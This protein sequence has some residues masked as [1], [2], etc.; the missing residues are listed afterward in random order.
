MRRPRRPAVPG[1]VIA[2]AFGQ[3]PEDHVRAAELAI[4]RAKR[5]AEPGRHVVV[6]PG[7]LTRLGRARGLA[8]PA[9]T[10]RDGLLTDPAGHAAV[11]SLRRA[12]ATADGQHAI[13]RRW[14]K[15]LSRTNGRLAGFARHGNPRGGSFR[16]P[17][18]QPHFE[19]PASMKFS[20]EVTT[21]GASLVTVAICAAAGAGDR[22]VTGPLRALTDELMA[23]VS[24][25]KSP[26]ARVG[27]RGCVA[28]DLISRDALTVPGGGQQGSLHDS[29]SGQPSG[30]PRR[31]LAATAA[32]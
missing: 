5:L 7:S 24:L 1:E 12:L 29:G 4:G 2:S 26:L 21:L 30:A 17:G 31:R 11:A 25:G 6:V 9:G 8:A 18:G 15:P 28:L 23:P 14:T 16:R 22:A 27:Q 10:R 20:T 32:A 13:D 3:S 19:L